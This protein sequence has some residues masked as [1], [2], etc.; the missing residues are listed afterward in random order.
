MKR[1]TP[2]SL[3]RLYLIVIW[4]LCG[5]LLSLPGHAFA[6]DSPEILVLNSDSSVEKYRETQEAFK[7]M[8]AQPVLEVDLGDEKWDITDIE[9]LLYDEDPDVIYCIGTKAYL[10]ANKYAPKKIIVFSSVINWRRLPITDQTYGISNEFHAAMELMQFRYVFPDIQKIGVLYS[11]KYTEEWFSNAQ[12]AAKEM[13]VNI[14]GQSISNRKNA[15]PAL[16]KLL[17]KI[18]AFWLISD[19]EVMS[20]KEDLLNILEA[21]D[22]KNIPVFSY[23]ETF[24]N[25]GAVFTVS[26]DNPTIGGQAAGIIRELLAGSPIEEHVQF[27]AGTWTV[28]NRKK[29]KEYGLQYNEDAIPTINVIIE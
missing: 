13:E 24:A 20:A 23:H 28:L 8:I 6:E 16:K 17:P 10:F 12:K 1:T 3:Y 25:F 15:I 14:S 5:V 18:D 2:T 29:V 19:P 26:V 11:T 9:D 22:A 7:A 21:C 4:L 27:P